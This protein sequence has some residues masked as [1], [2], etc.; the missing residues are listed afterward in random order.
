MRN[1]KR[2]ENYHGFALSRHVSVWMMRSSNASP[3]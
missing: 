2:M 1:L 3:L